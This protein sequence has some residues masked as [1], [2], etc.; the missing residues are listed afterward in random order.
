MVSNQKLKS[1][2]VSFK[3]K[4]ATNKFF[5]PHFRFKSHRVME[6]LRGYNTTPERCENEEELTF[7]EDDQM[8]TKS[9]KSEVKDLKSEI[10]SMISDK[11]LKS[12]YTKSP[13]SFPQIDTGISNSSNSTA[14]STSTSLNMSTNSTQQ[15]LRSSEV[16]KEFADRCKFI[17]MRLTE[18]ERRLL[19]VL[20]NALEV[21]EYTDTV[22][23]TYS[24]TGKSKQSRIIASLIDVLSIA[25]GLLMA[26]N[27]T[28]GET[29]LSEKSLND[30]VPLFAEI[31]EIGR[32][33]K[34]MNP[35][36]MRSTYGKLM[37]ILMD[38]ESYSIK[39]QMKVS[40]TLF[41]LSLI[42]ISFLSLSLFHF[43]SLSPHYPLFFQL[44]FINPI[45][46]VGLFLKS[47][48]GRD[49]LN[50]PLLAEATCAVND[51]LGEKSKRDLKAEALHKK[52]ACSEL[53][54]RYTSPEL[55]E[56]DLQV[57]YIIQ[58]IIRSVT[59]RHSVRVRI[60]VRVSQ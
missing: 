13:V 52:T 7:D 60:R 34:I 26:N 11:I 47:R 30:N 55:S 33:Y 22:D 24:H 50:D 6:E 31:F 27:L 37:W 12:E 9:D 41:V 32:R 25:C 16:V 10:K 29:L 56:V 4:S 42:S 48:G 2:R 20:E 28:K 14:N 18:D 53:I 44:N 38:T 49:L 51:Q 45:Q 59:V 54:K 46:T 21:C 39:T 5:S 3:L 1:Q 19:N 8:D 35:G 17:P 40:I 58:Y 23:V 57:R 36:K 43:H 15:S